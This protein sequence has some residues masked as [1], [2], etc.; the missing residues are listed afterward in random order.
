MDYNLALQNDKI[1]SVATTWMQIQIIILSD[2]AVWWSRD[3]NLPHDSR[4]WQTR[5]CDCPSKHAKQTFLGWEVL[6]AQ[7]HCLPLC[8]SPWKQ[9]NMF[10]INSRALTLPPAYGALI[11]LPSIT[12]S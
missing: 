7:L 6:S 1:I 11:K 4:V 3:Q 12:I 9:N 8:P 5:P 10:L 2:V